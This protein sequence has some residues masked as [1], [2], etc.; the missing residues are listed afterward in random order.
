[1][2]AGMLEAGPHRRGGNEKLARRLKMPR[3]GGLIMGDDQVILLTL[4]VQIL[5][6]V[7]I[8]RAGL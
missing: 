2:L 4:F 1:M 6:T 8:V 3:S 7:K 5:K